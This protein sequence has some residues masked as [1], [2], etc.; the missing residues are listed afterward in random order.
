MERLR[1]HG[2]YSRRQGCEGEQ[3]PMVDFRNAKPRRLRDE[4]DER[5]VFLQAFLREP[6]QV[7]SVVP[8]SRFVERGI[9][10]LRAVRRAR[11]IVAPGSGA[12][13]PTRGLPRRR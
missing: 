7:A 4:L 5:L 12:R 6:R 3:E 8:S 1:W 11:T 13:G 10:Q 2:L 9:L